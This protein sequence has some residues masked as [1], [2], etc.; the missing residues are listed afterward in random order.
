MRPTAVCSG[1]PGPEK[2]QEGPASE[3]EK[4]KG[5]KGEVGGLWDADV[6]KGVGGVGCLLM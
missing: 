5:E 3:K 4:K 6:A 2:R 1:A